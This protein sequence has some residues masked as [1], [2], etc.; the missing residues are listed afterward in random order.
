M[1]QYTPN[2]Y[3]SLKRQCARACTS[4]ISI[5]IK[6]IM[7][8]VRLNL[9]KLMQLLTHRTLTRLQTWKLFHPA[10][11]N[12]NIEQAHQLILL[13]EYPAITRMS[14]KQPSQIHTHQRTRRG[15]TT[16]EDTIMVKPQ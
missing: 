13:Q 16:N 3:F 5:F 15:M 11:L 2:S 6:I 14:S 1:L 9:G 4:D 10:S 12:P 7:D 8:Q